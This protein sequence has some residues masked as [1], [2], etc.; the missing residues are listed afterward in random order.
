MKLFKFFPFGL[1]NVFFYLQSKSLNNF[2]INY[3]LY[4]F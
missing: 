2:N 4:E 1:K 3:Y